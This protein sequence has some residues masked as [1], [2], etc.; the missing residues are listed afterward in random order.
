MGLERFRWCELEALSIVPEVICFETTPNPNALK[1][2]TT[3]R[4]G[5]IRS[6][7]NAEQ[8]EDAGDALACA[9]FAI[10]GVQTVLIHTE[11]V[12]V[13]KRADAKW[14]GIKRGVRAAIQ[15]E[16]DGGG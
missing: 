16:A 1:C 10:E 2:V 15:A 11:F 6:Y 12:T 13:C 7:F 4:P 14:I 9:L 8:A 5:A 3:A